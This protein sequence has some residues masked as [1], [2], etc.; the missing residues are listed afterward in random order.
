M[1]PEGCKKKKQLGLGR[2]T[3]DFF[4]PEET[5]YQSLEDILTQPNVLCQI[6][7]NVQSRNEERRKPKIAKG[8]RDS[9]P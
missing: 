9:D 1:N 7:K 5:P 2:G 8:T 3:K 6:K 4:Y